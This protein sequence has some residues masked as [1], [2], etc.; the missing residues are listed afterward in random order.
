MKLWLKNAIA[1]PTPHPIG[2]SIHSGSALFTRTPQAN[3]TW[4]QTPNAVPKIKI[5][6]IRLK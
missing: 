4:H 6:I 2:I 3:A 5:K 1:Y